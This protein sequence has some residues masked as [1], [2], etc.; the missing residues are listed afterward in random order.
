MIKLLDGM[1]DIGEGNI[2]WFPK[3][4]NIITKIN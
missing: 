1:I 3:R 2:S 4:I